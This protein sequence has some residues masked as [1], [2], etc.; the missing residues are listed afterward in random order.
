MEQLRFPLF[1]SLTGKQVVVVGGGKI[2]TRRA[3]V[4][5]RFGAA[6]TVIDPKICENIPDMTILSREYRPGDLKNAFLAVAATNDRA[7]NHQ[8]WQ[9]ADALGIPISV[10]DCPEECSFFFPAV[11]V[12]DGL[13]AGI[14]GDGSDHIRTAAA[15][16]RIRAVLE[17]E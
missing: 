8:V 3:A 6:V 11:C 4:L 10:A 12:T 17:D 15:A 14:V 7:V 9:E 13:V 1:V 16:K 5:A 2:G